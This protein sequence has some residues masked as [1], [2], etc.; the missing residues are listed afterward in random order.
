VGQ[1]KRM[2]RA[3]WRTLLFQK[4]TSEDR[5]RFGGTETK[6]QL[7]PEQAQLGS[8]RG[9]FKRKGWKGGEMVR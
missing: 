5:R 9:D 7:R 8:R 3:E 1:E 6:K 4:P 2:K